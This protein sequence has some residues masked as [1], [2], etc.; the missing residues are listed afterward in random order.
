MSSVCRCAGINHHLRNLPSSRMTLLCVTVSSIEKK[1]KRF[2]AVSL[3]CHP[4]T[5]MLDISNRQ[6]KKEI[7]KHVIKASS[8]PSDT[9]GKE[10]ECL[11]FS[12][13]TAFNQYLF[14]FFFERWRNYVRGWFCY[15]CVKK[16]HKSSVVVLTIGTEAERS[17]SW[18]IMNEN[19][20]QITN[21]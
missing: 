8:P 18:I 17:G 16:A 5:C 1:R 15:L 19:L 13:A 4:P 12:S 6:M 21:I 20:W 7:M 2:D 3:L 11:I 14:A 10:L 9:N